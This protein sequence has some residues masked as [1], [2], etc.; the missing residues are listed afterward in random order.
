MS[1]VP[2]IRWVG[3]IQLDVATLVGALV[4]VLTL[5]LAAPHHAQAGTITF[6]E[7]RYI[8]GL[9]WLFDYEDTD[10]DG[11]PGSN[12]VGSLTQDYGDDPRHFNPGQIPIPWGIPWTSTLSEVNAL[13]AATAGVGATQTSYGGPLAFGGSG[14]A[15]AFAT[16]AEFDV[17][18]SEA[19]SVYWMY[20]ATTDRNYRFTYDA[21]LHA[22]A[23]GD[24]YSA[25]GVSATLHRYYSLQNAPVVADTAV[26][27]ILEGLPGFHADST[28]RHTSGILT[29]G[30]YLLIAFTQA[31][32]Y[33]SLYPGQYPGGDVTWGRG[34]SASGAFDV[35]LTL[36]PVPE[37]TTLALLGIGGLGIVAKARRRRTQ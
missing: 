25:N 30:Q 26:S 35:R 10:G 6:L 19:A 32:T 17:A 14:A 11:V 16:V 13:D 18:I 34:G 29:P 4:V 8:Y 5:G 21:A 15:S 3:R 24:G 27:L 28:E 2:S 23:L 9:T 12:A 7:D 37:P 22:F 36:T 1:R 20:F 33:G 31:S